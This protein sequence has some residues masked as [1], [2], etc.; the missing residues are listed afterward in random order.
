MSC[1]TC[2]ARKPVEIRLRLLADAQALDRPGT[3]FEQPQPQCILARLLVATDQTVLVEHRQEPVNRAFVQRKP[4][5]NLARAQFARLIRQYLENVNCARYVGFFEE[6]RAI[7]PL[8]LPSSVFRRR[9]SRCERAFHNAG[10]RC[11]SR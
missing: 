6:L 2:V 3:E 1:F 11:V 8:L 10:A 4:L 9:V 7:E 5:G